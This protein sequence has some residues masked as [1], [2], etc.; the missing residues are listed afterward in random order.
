VPNCRL[1]RILPV[2]C[3]LL[4]WSC[5]LGKG[6]LT[7]RDRRRRA[8][9]ASHQLGRGFMLP[10]GR[11]VSALGQNVGGV[12]EDRCKPL[13]FPKVFNIKQRL[14][15][16]APCGQPRRLSQKPCELNKLSLGVPRSL[17]G[18]PL[19]TQDA[20]SPAAKNPA[21]R[22]WWKRTWRPTRSQSG[23]L[24]ALARRQPRAP[25][26]SDQLAEAGTDARKPASTPANHLTASTSPSPR[27]TH[28]NRPCAHPAVATDWP[29]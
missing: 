7:A 3:G 1:P 28:D 4:S 22:P 14:Q 6:P 2:S 21:W 17:H 8:A 18:Q 9:A 29:R 26:F 23:R 24:A 11:L 19:S 10:G 25:L 13:R 15:S 12:I 27:E 20:A 16:L 5:A